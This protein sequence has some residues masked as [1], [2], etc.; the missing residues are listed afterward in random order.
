[1]RI[2]NATGKGVIEILRVLSDGNIKMSEIMAIL[3]PVIKAGGNDMTEKEV[4]QLVWQA[5]LTEGIREVA[6]VMSEI[7]NA[8]EG[9]EGNEVEAEQ[10]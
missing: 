6:K 5:G 8:S 2:E 4:G 3:H 7:L 1:M 10:A 9:S